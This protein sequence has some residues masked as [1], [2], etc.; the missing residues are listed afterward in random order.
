M[1][2]SA[3]PI[4][5]LVGWSRPEV[6]ARLHPPGQL[7]ICKYLWVLRVIPKFDQGGW[8]IVGELFYLLLAKGDLSMQRSHGCDSI[9]VFAWDFCLCELTT[10][11]LG[12]TWMVYCTS[13]LPQG[14]AFLGYV[15][16]LTETLRSTHRSVVFNPHFALECLSQVGLSP[17]NWRCSRSI[18]L[19]RIW[20][21]L[22]MAQSF[23]SRANNFCPCAVSHSCREF[24]FR[25]LDKHTS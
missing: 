25:V 5:L 24:T 6:A 9:V 11:Y 13:R 3:V 16:V 10:P 14:N 2:S 12:L 7:N 23:A 15:G 18:F 20:R 8:E 19:S 22:R 1:L 17:A 4:T 21:R